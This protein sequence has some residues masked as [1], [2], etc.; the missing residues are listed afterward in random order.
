MASFGQILLPVDFSE[1]S[2]HAAPFA[3]VL[4][5]TC[6]ATVHLLHVFTPTVPDAG[7][8]IAMLPHKGNELQQML[9]EFGDRHLA[10]LGTPPIARVAMGSP[11]TVITEYARENKIDLI[12]IGTHARGVMNRIFRGSVSKSVMEHAPCPVLMVPLVAAVPVAVEG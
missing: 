5:E 7:A 6:G 8:G 9:A 3:R 10:N 2:D 12:V 4:A 1:L 11:V